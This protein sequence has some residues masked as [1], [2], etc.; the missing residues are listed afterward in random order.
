MLKVYLA[1]PEVFHPQAL[2]LGEA[3][4]KLCQDYG[5]EGVFPLDNVLPL[6]GLSR[7]RVGLT[8]AEANEKL[9]HQADLL[10]ANLTP[11]RGVSADVGTVYELGFARGLGKPVYAYSNTC[12]NYLER[13]QAWCPLGQHNQKWLDNDGLEVE[14]FDLADNL[15][16]Q[17]ATGLAGFICQPTSAQSLW[18]DLTAFKKILAFIQTSYL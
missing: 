11:F 12:Q 14:N 9:I 6:E 7:Q 5:F 18:T 2:V 1:G 15:M 4:K 17:G 13:H 10:I 3:K 16:L 8:I